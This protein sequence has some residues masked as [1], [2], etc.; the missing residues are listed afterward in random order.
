MTAIALLT[1]SYPY[2]P[3][4]Q[5]LQEEIKYWA[6][7]KDVELTLM[8]MF[9]QG[10]PLPLPANVHLDHSLAHVGKRTPRVACLLQA[11]VAQV[12]WREVL[13]LLR[14]GRMH[15]YC[16][17]KALHATASTL[18]VRDRLL[19]RIESGGK[20]DVVYSYWNDIQ[21]FAAALAKR[22]GRVRAL[23]SRAHG[24]DVYASQRRRG[25]IPLQSQFIRDFDSVC[26]IS[27][28]AARQLNRAYGGDLENLRI[29]RL[30]VPMPDRRASTS[31]GNK[32]NVL[33]VSFCVQYKRID[34]IVHALGLISASLPDTEINWVHIGG[35]PLLGKL[36]ELASSV[37]NSPKVTSTFLGDLTNEGVQRFM[38]EGAIDVFINASE[39]EGVPVS[40]MEAM[41][42]GIPAIAPN[43]GAIAELVED[44]CGQVLSAETSAE[45]IAGAVLQ[46]LP[47]LRDDQLR[48]AAKRAVDARYNAARNYPGFI[49]Y[50]LEVAAARRASFSEA[51]AMPLQLLDEK[52]VGIDAV[53]SNGRNG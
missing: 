33:S 18:D 17:A 5:F 22:N 27:A 39:V 34:R 21:A 51:G 26:T 53:R 15:P 37:L 46:M 6:A 13:Q 52:A 31:C 20:F 3:G 1:I 44:G 30:G 11:A 47:R 42:Y 48:D 10:T 43:V 24:F 28:D 41:S 49:R 9:A 32:L 7:R 35:G 38:S 16:Y 23:I 19:S 4:E 45:E 25:Y 8:P 12:F 29:M 50:V 40:I 2:P 36:R 14:D